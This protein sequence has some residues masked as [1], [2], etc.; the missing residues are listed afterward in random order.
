MFRRLPLTFIVFLTLIL[1]SHAIHAQT[2]TTWLGGTGAW[3]DA[4]FWSN[5]LPAADKDVVVDDSPFFLST[6]TG[7]SGTVNSLT[8]TGG[9]TVA[10]ISN[11]SI[12]SSIT[13]DGTISVDNGIR[14]SVFG[15]INN[16]GFIELSPN[17]FGDQLFIVGDTSL[18]GGGTIELNE[19]SS[20]IIFDNV[21][22]TFTNVDN[23]IRG[24]GSI[25]MEDDQFFDCTIEN[26]GMID[27]NVKGSAI[28]VSDI[29]SDGALKNTGI[30]QASNGG[31]LDIE[32][33]QIDNTSGTIRAQDGSEILMNPF[34]DP[35]FQ[36]REI[37]GGTIETAGTGT[38]ALSGIVKDMTLNGDVILD[39]VHLSGNIVNQGT[40]RGERE[41]PS[42]SNVWLINDVVLSGGGEIRLN[43]G[44]FQSP[45]F[46]KSF[47][48]VDNTIS[49]RGSLYCHASS[50]FQADSTIAPGF[51]NDPDPIAHMGHLTLT[52]DIAL[53]GAIEVDYRIKP[54]DPSAI[55]QNYGE[56][57]VIRC[58]GA[59]TVNGPIQL[60]FLPTA[61][62]VVGDFFDVIV[63]SSIQ[64]GPDVSISGAK[65]Y[66]FTYS[67]VNLELDKSGPYDAIRAVVVA[68]PGI[69]TTA[70]SAVVTRGTLASGDATSISASDDSDLSVRRSN[71]DVQ[72]VV[73]VELVGTTT[74]NEP[75]CMD[76]VV[77]SSVFAR[78]QVELELLAY[79]YLKDEFVMI[80]TVTASR[81]VDSIHSFSIT[82]TPS[83][84]FVDQ[85]TGEMK[86]RLRYSSAENRQ[87]FTANVDHV[88]W[89]IVE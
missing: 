14:L 83:S 78:T 71:T 5:G 26:M 2:T 70:D 30:L 34:F 61:K 47:V 57:D 45:Q 62:P 25:A 79:S 18:S 16:G 31:T 22:M 6:V 80:E 51:G 8:T 39:R 9:D 56:Q 1:T 67:V 15:N 10:L 41:I 42:S 40:M 12:L 88:Y 74:I 53:N 64:L 38:V 3:S 58:F 87:R 37:V 82:T 73:E 46:A 48:N 60:N 23:T 84:E 49:G 50:V 36:S 66:E 4:S 35:N 13:N 68:V 65:G 29:G 7:A 27:A 52:G 19:A 20:G 72:S 89:A 69:E 11:L 54:S 44:S 33:D 59:T 63:A 43:D 85:V 21:D 55:R 17:F 32:V 76:V 77:E 28:E 24:T 81:F 86:I 75:A